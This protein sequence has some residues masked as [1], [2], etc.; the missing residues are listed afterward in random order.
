MRRLPTLIGLAI[1]T[2]ASGLWIGC[3]QSPEPGDAI[4]KDKPNWSEAQVIDYLYAYVT[5][6]AEQFLDYE[7]V[8]LKMKLDYHFLNAVHV[9]NIE[10]IREATRLPLEKTSLE[11]YSLAICSVQRYLP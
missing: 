11:F 1:L 6:K 4:L 5:K 7:G 2:L 3:S 10:A 9:A 8:V